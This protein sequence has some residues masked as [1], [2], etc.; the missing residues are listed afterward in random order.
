MT[1]VSNSLSS[2][3]IVSSAL[4]SLGIF[5]LLM[6]RNLV[7]MLI[8]LE[9]ILNSVNINF[10]AFNKFCLTDKSLGQVFVI[11]VIALAA[12]EV[13]IGLSLILWLYRKKE[14]INVEGANELQG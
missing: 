13:C 14:S 8:A 2:Y 9:L 1:D 11:F 10:L 5:G 3:L 4:F 7:A 12:A 6:R